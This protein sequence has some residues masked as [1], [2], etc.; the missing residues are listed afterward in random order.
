MHP[1]L[2]RLFAARGVG[3]AHEIDDDFKALIPPA[4]LKNCEDAGVLLAGAIATQKKLLIVGDYDC[5]GA[6]ATA[7]G[8]RG[9]SAMGATVD[10]LLPERFKLGY[11]LSPALVE[12]AA[13]REPGLIITVDNGIADVDGVARANELGISVLIT[14]HHLPGAELPAAECIVNPNQPGCDFASKSLA[15]VGVMFYVLLSLRSELRRQGVFAQCGEPRLADLLD[16]VALGTVA[17]VVRLDHN[18]RILVSQGLKRIRLGQTR[19]G[20]LAIFKAAGRRDLSKISTSD[21]SF[22]AA[23]RLNAAG[24]MDDMSLGVECLLSDDPARALGLAQQLEQKNNERRH[25]EQHMQA[26]AE[27]RLAEMD[28]RQVDQAALAIFD[29]GWHPGIV[30]ILASRLKDKLHRPVFAFACGEGGIIKGSGRSI[31]GLH[32]RDLLDL[33]HKRAPDLLLHFGGHAAAAGATIRQED[34]E[35]FVE[36]FQTIAADHLGEAELTRTLESDGSLEDAYYTLPVAR[37]L[38]ETVWGQAFPAP[39]FTEQFRVRRQKLLQDKHLSL[40][41]QKGHTPLSG[42]CFNYAQPVGD[43]VRA[44][45]RLESNHYR[46]VEQLQ[47]NIVHLETLD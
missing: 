9:L 20:L 6:T 43:T 27:A 16:L 24:R 13:E 15:G 45:F 26:E 21:L 23:P 30:G 5:D 10:Y 34:F 8:L 38:Q 2:A 12:L 37:M 18:N 17:D 42:I 39:L 14:D 11:G 7:L 19:P 4:S 47:L 25:R 46:G 29:P 44:S 35:R 36:L 3:G 33:M 31:L 1:L 22:V 41:L 28:A 40:E 32:L